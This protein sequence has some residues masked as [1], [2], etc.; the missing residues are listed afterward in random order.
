MY[1]CPFC[2]NQSDSFLPFGLRYK[3]LSSLSVIGGG[4]RK[5]AL[6][7]YCKSSDRERLIYLYLREKTTVFSTSLKLLHIAP[8]RNLKLV[9]QNSSNIDYVDGD[10]KKTRASKTIDITD[11][12]FASSYFDVVICNH[13]LEHV[14]NEIKALQEL[15]RILKKGGFALIQ[16]PIAKSL[17]KTYENLSIVSSRDR[18]KHFG[19]WNHVR[20]YGRDYL[21]RLE[22]YGFSVKVI[23]PVSLFGIVYVNKYSLIANENLYV[24]TK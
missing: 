23:N 19:Q 13:V 18:A 1:L 9:F 16:V 11:I 10:I 5:N 4:Y 14:E 17:R 21:E 15:F 6:C 7:L 24:C 12:P 22:K 8:E 2:F 3:V 20:L